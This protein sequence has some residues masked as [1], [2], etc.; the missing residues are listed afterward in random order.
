[1]FARGCTLISSNVK[2]EEASCHRRYKLEASVRTSFYRAAAH[3]TVL[4]CACSSARY[5]VAASLWVLTVHRVTCLGP[6]RSAGPATVPMSHATVPRAPPCARGT[7]AARL[8]LFRTPSLPGRRSLT[9]ADQRS[10]LYPRWLEWLR[11]PGT[12][13]RCD[14]GRLLL[15]IRAIKAANVVGYPLRTGARATSPPLV[16]ILAL[17]PVAAALIHETWAVAI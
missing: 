13:R 6:S 10:P 11:I 5:C 7:H 16:L 12:A 17:P 9:N 8:C 4:R 1:M 2:C 14:G 3:F 15:L